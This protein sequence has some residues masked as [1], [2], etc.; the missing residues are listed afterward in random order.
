MSINLV[1]G[2]VT[3]VYPTQNSELWA[4]GASDWAEAV[5]TQLQ[6]VSVTGDIGPFTLVTILN[7]QASPANVTG[8]FL[9]PAN[10]RAGI[11][12]YF[13]QRVSGS[14]ELSEVGHLYLLYNDLSASWTVANV[15]NN[16]GVAGTT[17]S[18][19]NTG[20]VRYTTD[21]LVGQLSGVMKYRLRILQKV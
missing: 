10:I 12:E 3:Y 18:V 20:Q 1:V 2:G 21:N 17:F 16:V 5:T 11:V 15:G 6:Q 14:A 8:L 19:A 4:V 9:N 7:N 13:V